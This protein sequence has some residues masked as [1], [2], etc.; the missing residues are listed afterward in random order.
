MTQTRTI[1]RAPPRRRLGDTQSV[2]VLFLSVL[3]TLIAIYDL[4]LLTAIAQ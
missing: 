4:F 1:T 3:L 2:L